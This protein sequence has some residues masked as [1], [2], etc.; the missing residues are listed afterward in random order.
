MAN[1]APREAE[2][3][4]D[5]H[6]VLYISYK[7]STPF[8][9]ILYTLLQKAE[10]YNVINKF[11]QSV[12][13]CSDYCLSLDD[14]N[15]SPDDT[16]I[17]IVMTLK[18]KQSLF[19]RS[20]VY[21]TL[22]EGQVEVDQNYS[23]FCVVKT[24]CEKTS[25]PTVTTASPKIPNNT[26]I[27]TS[28]QV[29]NKN[30]A[31]SFVIAVAISAVIVITLL[32]LVLSIIVTITLRSRMHRQ[33][34]KLNA[35]TVPHMTNPAQ[36]TG[37]THTSTSSNESG[38]HSLSDSNDS[39]PPVGDNTANDPFPPVTND[40]FPAVR[41]T[42]SSSST[43]DKK[44][45]TNPVL[46]TSRTTTSSEHPSTSS[47][48]SGF[49]D[50]NDSGP[51]VS[52]STADDPFPPVTIDNSS[53]NHNVRTNPSFSVVR[54][55]IS[56]SSTKDK[57]IKQNKINSISKHQN[58]NQPPDIRWK[59]N[60]TYAQ[61]NLYSAPNPSKPPATVPDCKPPLHLYD[62][63]EGINE[64]RQ[65]VAAS[66]IP[67][68]TKHRTPASLHITQNSNYASSVNGVTRSGNGA[69]LLLTTN[70]KHP[71]SSQV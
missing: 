32:I 45:M 71:S 58:L 57:I 4:Q 67:R 23:M 8:T 43:K 17:T 10:I 1:I 62:D 55:T 69:K 37:R 14:I 38:V 48:E 31:T 46:L 64:S 22:Q 28:S 21:S 60:E 40:S 44:H 65:R 2:L 42:I 52:N 13:N 63:I 7:R 41:S 47:N 26:N 12:C 70:Y 35:R 54:S 25:P 6:Q 18:E 5:S 9:S 15:C 56:S 3:S 29:T 24:L 20:L 27:T 34:A 59:A 36:L 68:N 19:L 51:P 61:V 33:N 50:S 30:N 16:I 66:Q 49:Y 53:T 11:L 39:G